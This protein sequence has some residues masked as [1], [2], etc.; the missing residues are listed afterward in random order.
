MSYKNT[1]ILISPDCPVNE[2]VI[3]VTAKDSK[4]VHV[5]QYELLAE[6][7][8]QYDYPEL[9][10]ETHIRHKRIPEQEVQERRQE[11]WEELFAKKHACL[12]ASALPKRYGWGV[13]YDEEGKIAI[14]G[15]DSAE[16]KS[17]AEAPEGG[18]QLLYGMRSRKG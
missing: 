9:L 6:H 16:Y 17:F 10:F 13:H 11:I 8:Y 15:A 12:R 3:P 14:Y 5:I 7:P 18:I 4:P 2:G 1:F